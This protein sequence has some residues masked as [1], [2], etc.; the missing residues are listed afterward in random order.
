MGKN[1]QAVLVVS[2]KTKKPGFFKEQEA[3]AA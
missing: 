1:F 3:S 2:A